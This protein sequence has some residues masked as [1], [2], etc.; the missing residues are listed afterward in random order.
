M[1]PPVLLCLPFASLEFK[2][3]GAPASR[4]DAST[5]REQRTVHQVTVEAS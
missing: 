3:R 1:D 4:G 2:D 5:A